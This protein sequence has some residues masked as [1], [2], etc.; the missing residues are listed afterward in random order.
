MRV[1]KAKKKG[2]QELNPTRFERVA[3]WMFQSGIRLRDL[4]ATCL[5]CEDEGVLTAL[6][7]RQGSLVAKF[8][9]ISVLLHWVLF[10][11]TMGR[12]HMLCKVQHQTLSEPLDSE[13]LSE[14]GLPPQLPSPSSRDMSS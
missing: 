10:Q 13:Q 2:T 5:G 9:Q 11:S 4:L 6:P 1:N 12:Q 3:F 7:L 8:A 14:L